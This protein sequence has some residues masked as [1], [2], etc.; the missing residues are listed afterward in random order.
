MNIDKE[1]L[2]ALAG[3]IGYQL[4]RDAIWDGDCCNWLGWR[5]DF[6][7]RTPIYRWSSLGPSVYDGTAGVALFLA[8]LARQTAEPEY[9]STALGAMRHAMLHIDEVGGTIQSG[10]YS[11]AFGIG[12]TSVLV[13]LALEVDSLIAEGL[14]LLQNAARVIDSE[15][16]IDVVGGSAGVIPLLLGCSRRFGLDELVEL[17][18]LHVQHI[19]R[20]STRSASATGE[21][22][23]NWIQ[24]NLSP[25]G[26]TGYSHGNA[27]FANALLEVHQVVGDAD[28]LV[29]VRETL[30]FERRHFDV[31]QSNW[32]DLREFAKGST[33][34][35]ASAWCHGAPGIGLARIRTRELLAEDAHVPLEIKA[36]LD[37]T[38]RMLTQAVQ[39]DANYSLCHG[40]FG[41]AELLLTAIQTKQE[42][43][44]SQIALTDVLAGAIERYGITDRPWI[45]GTNDGRATPG[46]MLGISGIGYFLLRVIDASTPNVLLLTPSTI[47]HRS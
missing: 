26:L 11:G 20:R 23:R 47:D 46:L 5:T 13:G 33:L 28:L 2:L 38:N 25:M 14:C 34:S 16:E 35:C 15:H 17:A 31:A 30:R 41:N 24:P 39:S 18:Q 21:D 36:A 4:C 42:D 1:S 10:F 40:L 29:A 7:D 37:A 27:G 45:C 44:V 6:Q 8:Q 19:L 22:E 9:R 43:E 32:F 12:V 3:R